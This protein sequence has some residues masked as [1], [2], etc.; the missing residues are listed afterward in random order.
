MWQV[1]S[2][3]PQVQAESNRK[4]AGTEKQGRQSGRRVWAD[5]ET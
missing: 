5:L 2:G 4:W 3:H 1:W